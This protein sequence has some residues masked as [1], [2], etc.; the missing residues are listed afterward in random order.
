MVVKQDMRIFRVGYLLNIQNTSGIILNRNYIL[1][2]DIN[3]LGE[4]TKAQGTIRIRFKKGGQ[5]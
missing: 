1:N 3:E 2:A 4:I 5:T